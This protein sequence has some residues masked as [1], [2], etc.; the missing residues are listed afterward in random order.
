M[1]YLLTPELSFSREGRGVS[2]ALVIRVSFV[3]RWSV[4]S[5]CVSHR[6]RLV[7]VCVSKREEV[8]TGGRGQTRLLCSAL[9]GSYRTP[10]PPAPLTPFPQNNNKKDLQQQENKATAR[11]LICFPFLSVFRIITEAFLYSPNMQFWFRYRTRNI[12]DQINKVRIFYIIWFSPF[13]KQMKLMA[14]KLHKVL[15]SLPRCFIS[16]CSCNNT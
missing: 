12:W 2:W 4:V 13:L 15:P 9:T 14:W 16:S 10:N 7:T 5:F 6:L 11:E 3:H 8:Q 1:S